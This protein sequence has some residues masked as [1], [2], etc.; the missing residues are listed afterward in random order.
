MQSTET[1]GANA[2]S[3]DALTSFGDIRGKP[4]CPSNMD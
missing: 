4:P 2:A 1:G 3:V